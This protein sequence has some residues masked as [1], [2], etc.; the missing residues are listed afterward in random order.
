MVDFYSSGA[1]GGFIRENATPLSDY[2]YETAVRAGAGAEG[3]FLDEPVAVQPD[4]SAQEIPPGALP[5]EVRDDK[6]AM[7][8]EGELVWPADVVRWHGLK[9]FMEMMEEAKA[10]LASMEEVGLIQRPPS[11]LPD[12]VF[13]PD[14][15]DVPV[16]AVEE[17]PFGFAQGGTI[18]SD[19]STALSRARQAISAARALDWLYSKAAESPGLLSQSLGNIF[20][21]ETLSDLAGHL[22]LNANTLSG[23]SVGNA[24]GSL[25][26][27]ATGALNIAQ[28]NYASGAGGLIGAGLSAAGLAPFALPVAIGAA[29]IQAHIDSTSGK[30]PFAAHGGNVRIGR[31]EEGNAVLLGASGKNWNMDQARQVIQPQVDYLNNFMQQTGLRLKGGIDTSPYADRGWYDPQYT[32]GGYYAIIE[33]GVGPDA[34]MPV[35]FFD[36]LGFIP[37]EYFEHSDPTVNEWL[38]STDFRGWNDF[39]A[40]TKALLGGQAAPS[41]FRGSREGYRLNLNMDMPVYQGPDVSAVLGLGNPWGYDPGDRWVELAQREADRMRQSSGID[42]DENGFIRSYPGMGSEDDHGPGWGAQFLSQFANGRNPYDLTTNVTWNTAPD[43]DQAA[44][45]FHSVWTT[46]DTDPSS[47]V[48]EG[49]A[50]SYVPLGG[51]LMSGVGTYR[52]E[53]Y[54]DPYAPDPTWAAGN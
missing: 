6:P 28:G 35:N 15:V 42:V 31:D 48:P 49:Q 26:G 24:L 23:M 36:R 38:R 54:F 3:G 45:Q 11:E 4:G 47:V 18:Q 33:S 50:F 21:A 16:E 22:G 19:T 10:G 12:E 43:S 40:G 27:L 37:G 44:G 7:L 1:A 39:A 41:D 5:D 46:P 2:D 20:G 29:G 30:G 32:G 52:A 51:G 17:A 25:A 53:P 8:S 13:L 14:E 9:T 34:E